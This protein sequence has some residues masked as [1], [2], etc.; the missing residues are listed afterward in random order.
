MD[1]KTRATIIKSQIGF[2]FMYVI[3]KYVWIGFENIIF[4]NIFNELFTMALCTAFIIMWS[5]V[6]YDSSEG[7]KA[8]K[9]FDKKK[10]QK[11]EVQ[12]A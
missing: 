4:I 10:E 9:E 2:A 11:N 5:L 6:I 1:K 3:L 12:K 8:K 7:I